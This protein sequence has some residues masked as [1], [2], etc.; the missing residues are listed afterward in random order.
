V[1]GGAVTYVPYQCLPPTEKHEWSL[2]NSQP[3]LP[4]LHTGHTHRKENGGENDDCDEKFVAEPPLSAVQC[5]ALGPQCRCT[6]L[7][8]QLPPPPP[9]WKIGRDQLSEHKQGDQLPMTR[10]QN[11]GSTKG[12]LGEHKRGGQLTLGA[13]F[14]VGIIVWH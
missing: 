11:N 7:N 3:R 14:P 2:P 8:I 6:A 12:Q 1:S 5:S 13:N 9:H 4:K 10:W